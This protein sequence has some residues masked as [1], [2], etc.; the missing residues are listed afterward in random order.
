MTTEEPTGQAVIEYGVTEAALAELREK[1]KD[2][3]T[4]TADNIVVVKAN[5]KELTG[6]RTAIEARRNELLAGARNYTSKVNSIAAEITAAVVAIEQPIK[7]LRDDF[8]AAEKAEKDK[9]DLIEKERTGKI[10]AKIDLIE[11]RGRELDQYD[12]GE[13]SRQLSDMKAATPTEEVFQEFL[14]VAIERWE[15]TIARITVAHGKRVAYEVEQQKFKEAQEKLAKEQA[16]AKAS[17]D[18]ADKKLADERAAFEAEKAKFQEA[19]DAEASKAQEA[20][21]A[22]A[23][24]QAMAE[25]E[26]REQAIA[27]KAAQDAADAVIAAQAAAE[28]AEAERLALA[29]DKEKLLNY[30]KRLE[31]L[32]EDCPVPVNDKAR[33]VLGRCLSSL[34]AT[35]SSLIDTAERL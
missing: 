31:C 24:K 4:A 5:V 18:A 8:V 26:A 2:I 7:K 3:R 17:K 11:Q 32:I 23:K 9:A 29:P 21:A 15:S 10:N 22:E 35:H 16:E 30:A 19:K 1:N 12:A 33:K 25:Q 28:E 13:L 27:Q 34:Q 20:T 6:I 14:A